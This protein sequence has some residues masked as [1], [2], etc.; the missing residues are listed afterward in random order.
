[1]RFGCSATRYEKISRSKN[2][3][4]MCKVDKIKEEY[5]DVQNYNFLIL[6]ANNVRCTL[7][8]CFQSVMEVGVMAG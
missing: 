2:V 6:W 7:E 5:Y 1:V 3:L 8:I 4:D